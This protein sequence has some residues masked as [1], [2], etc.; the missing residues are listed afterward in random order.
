MGYWIVVLNMLIWTCLQ[1]TLVIL[2]LTPVTNAMSLAK[3]K[4]TFDRDDDSKSHSLQAFAT[5]ER[6]VVRRAT[7]LK[8]QSETVNILKNFKFK[9]RTKN[10]NIIRRD[11]AP[12]PRPRPKGGSGG[13]K[14]IETHHASMKVRNELNVSTV[15]I[16]FTV[17]AMVV[18]LVLLVF[19]VY[20]YWRSDMNC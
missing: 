7:E 19:L 3:N 14:S 11:A 16:V 6:R 13:S 10:H 4:E 18:V 8:T 2:W 1:L 17:V 15:G 9:D 5:N 12:D 20:Y